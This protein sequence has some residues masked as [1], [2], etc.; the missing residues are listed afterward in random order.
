MFRFTTLSK[1]NE[2]CLF[3]CLFV[4]LFLRPKKEKTAYTRT[5]IAVKTAFGHLT[6]TRLRLHR[7]EVVSGDGDRQLLVSGK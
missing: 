3:V 6:L 4:C 5:R 7:R 2:H 1:T